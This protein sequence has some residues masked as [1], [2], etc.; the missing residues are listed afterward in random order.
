MAGVAPSAPRES[1]PRVRTAWGLGDQVLASAT[2]FALTVFA[3]RTLSPHDF[4]AFAIIF[5]LYV[6]CSGVIRGFVSEPLVVRFSSA[7]LPQ[8]QRAVAI[9]L[10]RGIVA[11]AAL[12]CVLV[13]ASLCFG[14]ASV[15]N[16]LLL[17]AVLFPG[18][19]LQDTARFG[20]MAL[21]RPQVAFGSDVVWA[22]I[23]VVS[24]SLLVEVGSVS[25][26]SLIVCWAMGGLVAGVFAVVRGRLAI[27]MSAMHEA[28]SGPATFGGRFAAD[29]LISQGSTQFIIVLLGIVAS[30]SEAGTFRVALAAFGPLVVVMAGARFAFIPEFARTRHVPGL[31]HRRV[32]QATAALTLTA[33]SWG[34][35]VFVMP[36][37]FG[38]VFFGGNWESAHSL[39]PAI[40]VAIAAGAAETGALCGI[41]ALADASGG[42]RARVVVGS[43]TVLSAGAGAAMAGA[44]GAAIG[45]ALVALPGFIVWWA[46]FRASLSQSP[47][48]DLHPR[49]KLLRDVG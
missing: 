13:A 36:L 7:P 35:L 29:F 47:G 42:L 23:Q 3:A 5:A 18:L 2:N 39:I 33:I 45:A 49:T 22:A 43:L 31:L 21:G 14:G 32:V 48:E 12:A 16:G 26:R 27:Q 19:V 34:V 17:M 1:S 41:R 15:R 6:L 25:L 44:K 24:F 8:Q 38:T 4:G 37:G 28:V 20:V 11:A 40:T 10:C 46:Q 9:A 30:A